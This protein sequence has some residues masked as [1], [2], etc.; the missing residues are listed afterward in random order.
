[1]IREPRKN[2][3]P[4]FGLAYALPDQKTVLR[5]GYGI[6][7]ARIPGALLQNLYLNNGSYQPQLSLNGSVAGD[8]RS[9]PLSR[10]FCRDY[11]AAAILE[12]STRSSRRRISGNRIRSRPTS[13][14]SGS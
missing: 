11:R 5:G 9:D 1:M 3:A 4:R 2:F 7:Y 12:R 14:L 10:T 6:F 8:W 13:R